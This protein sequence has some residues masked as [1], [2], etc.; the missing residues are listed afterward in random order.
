MANNLSG[1]ERLLAHKHWISLNAFGRELHLC[2][3]CSGT[4]LGGLGSQ[5]LL[6]IYTILWGNSIPQYLGFLVFLLLAMPLI[7]DWI[8]QSYGLRESNNGLRIVTG[9]LEGVGITVLILTDMQLQLKFLIVAS[10]SIG[11][12][13]IGLV[14]K[15]ITQKITI[16]E[17]SMC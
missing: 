2:A 6:P 5:L 9:L 1:W 8:T 16:N 4:I 15:R 3:R 11:I 13:C 17:Y 7:I 12:M 14:G 10:I